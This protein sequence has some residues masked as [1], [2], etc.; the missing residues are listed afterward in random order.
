VP[1]PSRTIKRLWLAGVALAA[2]VA[3]LA[4]GNAFLPD[5]KRLTARTLGHDFLAFYT[6]GEFVRTN[7]LADLYDL[8]K[9][10][11]FQHDLARREN[12]EI[13]QS[14]GPFWNPPFYAWPFAPISALPYRQAVNTWWAVNAIALAGALWMLM[15]VLRGNVSSEAPGHQEGARAPLSAFSIQHSQF[16]ILPRQTTLLLPLLLLVSMPLIQAFSHGQNSFVSLALL[17]ATVVCWR[18][19]KPIRAGLIAGLLMYKPQLGAVVAVALVLTMGWRA[20]I[21]LSITGLALAAVTFLTLPGTLPDYLRLMPGNL[22]LFQIDQPYLWD[23]HVTLRA[24]WR[25]L[26]QGRDAGDMLWPARLC[27][28]ASCAA[29]AVG[30]FRAFLAV[31]RT[32]SPAARDL[33]IAAVVCAMPLVMP[34]YFDYDLLLLAIPA[35][36]TARVVLT[37]TVGQTFLSAQTPPSHRALFWSWC[38]LFLYLVVNSTIAR[39]THVNGTV[40]L[41]TAI[42]TLTI[43]QTI[44]HARAVTP[45]STPQAP[46]TSLAAA[47]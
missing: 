7:R 17:A 11:A 2:F 22:K 35:V 46:T 34:F 13:G 37:R 8:P 19:N 28:L 23:R 21:G 15:R 1:R 16:S 6:A 33:F 27:W 20:L 4:V 38:A 43:R 14:F 9:V 25:L 26:I 30:L 44:A 24:F 18:S 3:T 10:K 31:R 41:L 32:T 45:L 12:L 42:T 39:V 40:L 47:A 36:L 29:I 5:H